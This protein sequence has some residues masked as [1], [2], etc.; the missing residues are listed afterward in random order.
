MEIIL[1][2]FADSVW[3]EILFFNYYYQRPKLD[4]VMGS[5]IWPK[6]K[7]LWAVLSTF[8]SFSQVPSETR[9]LTILYHFLSAEFGSKLLITASSKEYNSSV[10]LYYNII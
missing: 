2:S 6:K 8:F 3:S 5:P 10:F 4:H 7:F 1:V 9:Q